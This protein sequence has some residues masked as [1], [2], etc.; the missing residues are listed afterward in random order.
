MSERKFPMPDYMQPGSRG[1]VVNLLLAFLDPEARAGQAG[2]TGIVLDGEFGKIGEREMKRWQTAHGIS[3]DG[4]CGPETRAAM[5]E[6]GFDLD[7]AA[8]K[9]PLKAGVSKFVQVDGTTLYWAP[10]VKAGENLAD[11]QSYFRKS[12]HPGN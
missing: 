5:K 1:P 3:P 6:A 9:M 2:S 12:R 10:F 7:A 8:H 4:G 11:V